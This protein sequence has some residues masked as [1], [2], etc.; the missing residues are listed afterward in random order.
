MSGKKYDSE[1]LKTNLLY[2]TLVNELEDVVKVLTFGA[3]KYGENN[4]QQLEGGFD[5]YSAAL[6]RHIN[7]RLRGEHT[8]AE[9]GLSHLSH[10]ACC[11]LFMMY[12]DNSSSRVRGLNY[13]SVFVDEGPNPV[14]PFE[15]K[16]QYYSD[17]TSKFW[18]ND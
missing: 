1:K 9:S 2:K 5:R 6:F 11:L 17:H 15:I 13:H 8:D 7:A 18:D 16:G 12:L 10:A 14:K 3:N 4:W